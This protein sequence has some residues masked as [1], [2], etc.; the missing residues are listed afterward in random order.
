[1]AG[2]LFGLARVML[3]VAAVITWTLLPLS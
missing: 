3:A 1:M 2:L